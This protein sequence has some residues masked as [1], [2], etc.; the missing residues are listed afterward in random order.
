MLSILALVLAVLA[1]VIE[2]AGLGGSVAFVLL[3][4]AVICLCV[5]GLGL[6]AVVTRRVP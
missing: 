4:A 5:G 3:A 2:L 6:P 1:L